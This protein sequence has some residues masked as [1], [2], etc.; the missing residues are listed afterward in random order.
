M[1]KQIKK[2]FSFGL[3]SGVITTLGMMV[4]LDS[5]TH[6]RIVVLGAILSIAI[7][8]A[9]SDSLGVHV[10]E[11]SEN[12]HSKKE[13]WQ[14]TAFTF[15]TK[16]TCALTFIL[17]VIFLPLNWAVIVSVA[18]GLLLIAVFSYFVGK[19]EVQKKPW[20]VVLEHILIAIVV[21]FITHLVGDFI[22]TLK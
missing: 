15:I 5:G 3:I 2:G 4:G 16:F 11:E 12:S 6:S 18:W 1:D 7:A 13:I 19:N 14:A 17:P 22:S 10:S 20:P 8:D 21:I 9:F